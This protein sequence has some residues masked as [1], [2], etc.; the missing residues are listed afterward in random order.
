M[1]RHPLVSTVCLVT[2][3]TDHVL[4]I[5]L[6]YIM[7]CPETCKPLAPPIDFQ[8]SSST[9][10]KHFMGQISD[11]KVHFYWVTEY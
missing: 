7:Y 3:R 11:E 10:K 2:L 9:I 1:L 6:N 4:F 5:V 8:F